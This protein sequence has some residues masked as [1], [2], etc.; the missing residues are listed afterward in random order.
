MQK[1]KAAIRQAEKTGQMALAVF[2]D[3]G[4]Q[5]A[6]GGAG[7]EPAPPKKS[8][9]ATARKGANVA[10]FQA[11]ARFA[12]GAARRASLGAQADA[13]A[14]GSPERDSAKN[15]PEPIEDG[16]SVDG[17]SHADSPLA[18]DA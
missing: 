12:G 6:R 18:V 7:N 14:A 8:L 13:S 10:K 4:G 1:V 16:D 11:V 9:G 17:R 15:T 3:F 2:R 5:L